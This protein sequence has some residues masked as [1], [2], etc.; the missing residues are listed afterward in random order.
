MSKLIN[1][2]ATRRY[3]LEVANDK[4]TKA[5]NSRPDTYTDSE[6]RVWNYGRSRKHVKQFTSVSADFID[7]LDYD[8]RKMIADKIEKMHLRGKT[9]K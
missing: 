5:A 1:K 4:V 7:S 9:V 6:G 3:I 8:F 2:M